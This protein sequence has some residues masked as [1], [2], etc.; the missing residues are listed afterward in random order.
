[1]LIMSN[2]SNKF[3]KVL[4]TA[5]MFALLVTPLVSNNS[6][7]T[8]PEIGKESCS[9]EQRLEKELDARE[10]YESM[11]P[12]IARTPELSDQL[13]A[14]Y[15]Q[16]TKSEKEERERELEAS[17]EAAESK[18]SGSGEPPENEEETAENESVEFYI[19]SNIEKRGE[20]GIG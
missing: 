11:L 14:A 16:K 5:K 4:A 2:Q 12:E 10:I 19:D 8:Q 17:R 1:M 13:E 3:E 6:S 9:I 7:N 15:E 18:A 20:S